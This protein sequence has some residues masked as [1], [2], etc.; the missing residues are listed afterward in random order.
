MGKG[1]GREEEGGKLGGVV[2]GGTWDAFIVPG[3]AGRGMTG[4]LEAFW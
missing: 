3:K 4:C 1:G 2:S